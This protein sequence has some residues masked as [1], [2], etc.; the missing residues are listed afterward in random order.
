MS[1]SSW[2]VI[3][4]CCGVYAILSGLGFSIWLLMQH[5]D[6]N[7]LFT[8]AQCLHCPVFFCQTLRM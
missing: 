7:R 6:S 4:G 5:I 1:S 3:A 8:L 2:F